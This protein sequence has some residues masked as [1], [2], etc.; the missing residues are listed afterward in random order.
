MVVA[1]GMFV[2]L[3]VLAPTPTINCDAGIVSL[4][5]A[6]YFDVTRRT[7]LDNCYSR[8]TITA[9]GVVCH[10]GGSENHHHHCCQDGNR[11]QQQPLARRSG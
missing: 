4:V 10:S 5:I 7:T 6:S 9:V 3:A 8:L 2:L 1:L 11:G